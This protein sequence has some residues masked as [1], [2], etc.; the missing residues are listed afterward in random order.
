MS[1]DKLTAALPRLRAPFT[2]A[3]VKWKIQ[4]NPKKY[5]NGWGKATIVAFIDAR[6]VGER[7]NDAVGT[8]WSTVFGPAVVQDQCAAVACRLTVLGSTREDVGTSTQGG[9]IGVKTAYSDAFKRA[10]V[11][12]GIG[13][14]LYAL[15][16]IKLAAA[17][18]NQFGKN[19]YLP[20]EQAEQLRRRYAAWLLKPEVVKR[21][22]E[23]IDHGDGLHSDQGAEP[24]GAQA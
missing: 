2:P 8:D 16:P 19:W 5:D 21:F 15:P 6:L 10:A 22:G 9:E 20:D 7:L 1:T 24:V 23:P 13:A 3:A 11:H 4:T 18:L 17:H 14:P 12:F